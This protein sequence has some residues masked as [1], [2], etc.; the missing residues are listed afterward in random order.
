MKLY[1]AR[2]GESEANTLGVIS[3][4]GLKHGLTDT[5]RLARMDLLD[6]WQLIIAN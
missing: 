1:F 3:N 5:G 2:H 6:H 4:R